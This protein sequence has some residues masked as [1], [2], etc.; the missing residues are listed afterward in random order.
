M[1]L[2]TTYFYTVAIL[3]WMPLLEKDRFKQIVLDSLI[4]LVE[5]D[6]LIVY[7]FV[8]MPNHI[9]VIWEAKAK[10]GKEM[11]HASF[12]KYTGHE[13]LKELRKTDSLLLERFKVNEITREYQFWQKKGLPILMFD[14]KILEQKLDYTHYN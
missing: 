1:E 13:F 12:M 3:N 5:K 10:N 6:K 7:G 4:H 11:P 14:R 2:N 8:I 9:H